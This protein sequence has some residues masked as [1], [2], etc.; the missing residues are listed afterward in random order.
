MSP[1]SIQQSDPTHPAALHLIQ[2]LDDYL[3]RIYPPESN[4][5]MS[6]E[7]LRQPHIQFLTVQK[8]ETVAGCGA[9]VNHGEYGE[10]KRF[11]IQPEF[12]GMR[13]GHQLL[14]ALET[15][16]TALHLP[17]LRLESGVFQPEALGLFTKLGYHRREPFGQYQANPYSVFMEKSL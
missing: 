17:C 8:G 11:F 2:Q 9:L 3:N 13:L 15:R 6:A 14:Q 12:R 1:V 10:I 4:H 5:L 7:A 16:A